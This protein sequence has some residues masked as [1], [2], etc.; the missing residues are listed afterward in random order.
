MIVRLSMYHGCMIHLFISDA[1][2]PLR[3]NAIIFFSL[4]GHRRIIYLADG[5]TGARHLALAADPDVF[6]GVN[7]GTYD[8]DVAF[9]GQLYKSEYQDLCR[10][11]SLYSRGYLEGIIAAQSQINGGYII[12][13]MLTADTLGLVNADFLKASKGRFSVTGRELSYTL[14]KETTGRQRYTALA[15]LSDRCRVNVYSNDMDGRLEKASFCGYADYYDK[16][17]ACV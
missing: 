3:I 5:V 6:A 2:I 7:T 15:L 17:P 12:D 4:T 8:C 13:E 10:G 1:L 9:L 14:A 16:M 11:L